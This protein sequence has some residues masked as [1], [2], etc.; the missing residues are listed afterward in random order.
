MPE[1]EDWFEAGRLH[2]AAS[3]GNIAE[4]VRLVSAG[5]KV[6]SIDD[7]TLTPLHYA[8][9][10]VDP[11][12]AVW[13][14]ENGA[15]VNAHDEPNIG[16]TPLSIAVQHG[17]PAVV[18]ALL[19]NGADADIP[20]WMNLSARIRSERLLTDEGRQIADLIRKYRPVKQNPGTSKT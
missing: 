4:M 1:L 11:G 5:W 16:E 14:L 8:A 20:G 9:E 6:E 2:R 10:R 12:A 15:D 18:E 3:D 13:L 19:L 17:R 7:M